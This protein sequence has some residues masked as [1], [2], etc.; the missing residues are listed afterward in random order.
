MSFRTAVVGPVV[1][2]APL[3]FSRTPQE[4]MGRGS[5]L[6]AFTLGKGL[7]EMMSHKFEPLE[8]T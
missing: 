1:S 2:K 6:G 3:W 7:C 8:E 5:I 4:E